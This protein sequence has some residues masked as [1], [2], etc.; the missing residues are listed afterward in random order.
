MYMFYF[1]VHQ[2]VLVDSHIG[3]THVFLCI[4]ICQVPRKLFEHEATRPE[5]SKLS[6][7]TLQMLMQ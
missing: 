4:N 6:Q 1:N 7:G 2:S 3:I 5:C